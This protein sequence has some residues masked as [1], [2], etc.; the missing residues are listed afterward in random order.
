MELVRKRG[1]A[2][3]I[4]EA[5]ILGTPWIFEKAFE[6]LEQKDLKKKWQKKREKLLSEKIDVIKNERVLR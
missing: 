1:D 3:T 6:L 5:G 4:S 2:M